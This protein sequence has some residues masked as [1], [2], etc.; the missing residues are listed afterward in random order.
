M[1]DNAMVILKD[2]ADKNNATLGWD[3]N[4]KNVT[5]ND[6]TYTPE[7]LTAMGGKVENNRWM[8]DANTAN[9]LVGVN[10]QPTTQDDSLKSIMDMITNANKGYLDTQIAVAGQNRDAQ[11]AELKAS[12]NKAIQEGQMSVLEA[13]E[14]Y[15][16]QVKNINQTAYTDTEQTQVQMQNMGI[17][18]SQQGLGMMAS[19]QARKQSLVNDNI[20]NRDNRILQINERI[21]GL[22]S[23]ADIQLNK[24]NADYQS[25]VLNAQG[26]ANY[27]TSNVMADLQ[28]KNYFTE[29]EQEFQKFLQDDA[30]DFTSSENTAQRDFE[31]EQAS[32]D[33]EWKSTE[34]QL[35]RN[36]DIVMQ[37]NEFKHDAAMTAT[38]FANDMT[39]MAQQFGFSTQLEN[40]KSSNAMK[41]YQTKLNTDYAMI[42]KEENNKLLNEY[43]KYNDP[44][45]IEYKT[46][47]AQVAAETQQR[48]DSAIQETMT[49][50]MV[51]LILNKPGSFEQSNVDAIIENMGGWD[52]FWGMD[53]TTQ[54]IFDKTV[55]AIDTGLSMDNLIKSLKPYAKEDKIREI[56]EPMY[57]NKEWNDV[58]AELKDIMKNGVFN[59]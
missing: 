57:A 6:K 50:T 37:G 42:L 24:I 40:L 32:I 27:N 11:I 4:T 14:A 9:N 46:Y 16:N 54:D 21:K 36:H 17:Q 41:E 58:Y 59:Q 39:A 20:K 56:V 34:S 13:K 8:F 45:S 44:N 29:K 2:I 43:N 35:N 19:D 52:K 48:L 22:S 15:D 7:Q 3:A 26:Q 10:Q 53:N 55:N 23:D 28:S 49:G 5:V 33:R 18:N 47:K 30:Q 25:N 38:R 12:L 51:D 1:A 31:S